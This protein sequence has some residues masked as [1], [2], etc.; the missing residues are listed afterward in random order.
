MKPPKR[1]ITHTAAILVGGSAIIATALALDT[2]S[3]DK[4]TGSPPAVTVDEKP[5]DRSLGM[6][7]SFSSVIKRV[8]P[9]V[10]KIE[11]VGKAQPAADF[12]S[13]GMEFPFGD[14]GGSE[15]RRFF[16]QRGQG[17]GQGQNPGQGLG[18]GRMQMPREHGAASGVIVTPDGYVLTNNH[19]VDHA[20][21][22]EV[23][24]HDGRTLI[25]KVV[26]TDPKSDLAVVKIDAK[27]LPAI[28]FADSSTAEVGDLV[29]A[30][31]N[32]FG[33]GE[34]VTLGMISATGRATMG[35]DYEDFIQTD[36]AINPGNSGGALVDAQGRLIGINTAIVSRGGGND[37]VGFAIPAN[38]AR[39]VMNDLISNGRVDRAYLG[40]MIQ[41]LTP[42]LADQF[43]APADTQG[44]LVGDVPAKSPASKAGLESGDIITH[45]AG[46][47]VKDARSLK[48]AVANHKPGES[49]DLKVLRDG[50]EKTLTATLGEQPGADKAIPAKHKVGKSDEDTLNGVGV[51]DLNRAAREESNIPSDVRGAV[52][53]DVQQDSPAWEAGL[54]P[55][56]VIQQINRKPVTSAEDAVKLTESPSSSQTLVKVW[57]KGGSRF[58]TV[59]ETSSGN[60]AG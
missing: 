42:T 54:R 52:I 2:K 43:K 20:D 8:T 9:S 12:G 60:Q 15:L 41:D 5:L 7:S 4:E 19:V 55:G 10:V 23:T 39:G 3:T 14:L 53:T 48:L 38:M 28:S 6:P 22:V 16:E 44:A 17:R 11:V 32:P 29:L 37:G 36:A 51:A 27:N 34:S 47:T 57:S 13:S 1:I 49:A 40:V 35:L 18:R 30:A 21:K 31:G 24:L 45:F 33:L 50:T 58:V 46:K 56:D 26:G 25:A 59:D